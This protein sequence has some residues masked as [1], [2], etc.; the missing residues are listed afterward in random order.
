MVKDK[1]NEHDKNCKL[2]K[3]GSKPNFQ[4]LDCLNIYFM[5]DDWCGHT[6]HTFTCKKC[7]T[8]KH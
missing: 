2:F 6:F 3:I 4:C 8:A 7:A 1:L 5:P